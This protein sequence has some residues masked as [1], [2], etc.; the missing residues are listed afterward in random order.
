MKAK[1]QSRF[2]ID[3]LRDRAG[4]TVLVRG[5][6]YHRGG[7][8][9]ILTVETNRVLAQVA[10]TEDYRTELRGR[11]RSIA[12]LKARHRQKRNFMKLLG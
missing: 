7:Q 2:S 6:T 11:G 4:D 3:A 5:E 12:T 10:G 9:Q 1:A 8:V